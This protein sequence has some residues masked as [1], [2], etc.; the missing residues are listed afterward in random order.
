MVPLEWMYL[1]CL[2]MAC[3]VFGYAPIATADELGH[4]WPKVRIACFALQVLV[5]CGAFWL[6]W[7][8]C[9]HCRAYAGQGVLVAN[10]VAAVIGLVLGQGAVTLF[11]WG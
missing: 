3:A 9:R 10:L 1:L 6:A 2:V 5:S 8:L 4:A 11:L 7:R